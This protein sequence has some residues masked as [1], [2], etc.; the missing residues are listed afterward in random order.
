MEI[1]LNLKKLQK[2]HM[3]KVNSQLLIKI[4]LML[5]HIKWLKTIKAAFPA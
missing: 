3:M 1:I 5:I 2:I 4:I